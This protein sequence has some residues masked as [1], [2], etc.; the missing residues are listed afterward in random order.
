MGGEVSPSGGGVP[1][2]GIGVSPPGIGVPRVGKGVPLVGGG[3]PLRGEGGDKPLP[4]RA[5]QPQ[6]RPTQTQTTHVY[7][8]LPV[9]FLPT[10]LSSQL[11]R[12]SV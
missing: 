11:L 8:A 3:A 10:P 9:C 7:A 5:F 4:A 2:V 12:L 6:C 1:H